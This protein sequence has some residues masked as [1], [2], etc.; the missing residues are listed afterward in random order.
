MPVEFI[1]KRNRLAA[2]AETHGVD[3]RTAGM[4]SPRRL[5]PKKTDNR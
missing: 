2:I 4:Q 5:A 3:L 1:A